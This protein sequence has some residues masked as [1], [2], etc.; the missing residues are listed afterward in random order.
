MKE[1]IIYYNDQKNDDFLGINI[2]A[3]PL[4]DNYKYV[5]K[6]IFYRAWSFAFYYFIAKP[7]VFLIVKMRYHQKFIN[8][9]CIRV[10]KK[11]GAFLYG[12]HTSGV[13]DSFV[14]NILL[15]TR[16][17][18]FI[19]SPEA[20]SI[21]F[22]KGLLRALGVMPL[23]DKL[24]LKKKLLKA[25]EYRLSQK[26]LI[27]I[28]PEAHIWP[29][30]TKVREYDETSF[31][32][33]AMY[34]KPVYALTNCYQKRKLGKYPKM[35]TFVDGPYYP[36]KNLSLKENAKYLRDIVYNKM[37]ERTNEHSTYEY[38]K[39]IKKED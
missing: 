17:N 27:T 5:K 28:Y 4:K 35:I 32:Y 2:N 29:F 16:K 23:S 34:N 6:N 25:I 10:A 24:S 1:R 18:Y 33:A 19:A 37:V 21:P 22:L 26:A 30:Y 11:T 7:L 9:K 12:N 14:P 20:M 3:K 8:K 15:L 39:Y 38:I 13:G 31:K 36:D